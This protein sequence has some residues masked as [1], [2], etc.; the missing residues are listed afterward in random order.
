MSLDILRET[1]AAIPIEEVAR[2]KTA[3]ASVL[4]E[5]D[6]LVVLAR[7][8]K[9]H[10]ALIAVGE[11]AD[12]ADD[13]E[14]RVNAARESQSLWVNER[15]RGKAQELV[16]AEARA[17]HLRSQMVAAIRWNLRRDPQAQATLAA[18]N[19]GDGADD[20]VQDLHD[21][22]HLVEKNLPAFAADE[23]F[24]AAAAVAEV[25]HVA[26]V[27]STEI[28]GGRTDTASE[29]RM[30]L[31]DRAF[32]YLDQLVAEIRAAGRYAFRHNPR[33]SRR[34]S[35]R[36]QRMRRRSSGTP[37]TPAVAPK[38]SQQSVEVAKEEVA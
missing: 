6:D 15:D 37:A 26:K 32:T 10:K 19:V 21:L 7:T 4:Q 22:A 18:I 16:E 36:T 5:A 34:F 9:V 14:Q 8:K 12:F 20:G 23:S 35:S 27:L 17:N 30:L 25:R 11:P 28:S 2:P 1:L 24:D 29:D 38:T 31:R 33:M 13:L 3:I